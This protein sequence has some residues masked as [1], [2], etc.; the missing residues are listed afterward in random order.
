MQKVVPLGS[1]VLEVLGDGAEVLL[2]QCYFY[3]FGPDFGVG[4]RGILNLILLGLDL[5]TI[6]EVVVLILEEL[7]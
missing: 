4:V 2:I 3:S 5:E 1:P 6:A 7:V